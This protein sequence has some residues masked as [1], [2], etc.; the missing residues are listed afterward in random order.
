MGRACAVNKTRLFV[1]V[2]LALCGVALVYALSGHNYLGYALWLIAALNLLFCFL[3]KRAKIA[4]GALIALGIV[5]FVIIEIPIVE[6]AAPDD[7]VS[8]D[9]IIVLGAA[10]HGDTPSLSMVERVS[11]AYDYMTAHPG[12]TAVLSGGQ[13]GNENMSEAEAMYRWLLDKGISPDRLITED[14]STSTL[15]NLRFSLDIIRQ[16]GGDTGSVAVVSSEYHI[17]R[18]KL[19]G[20]TLGVSLAGIPAH[21]SYPSVRLN[22]FIREAFG[23]VYQKT[24]G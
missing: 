15:E 6:N 1:S 11:A 18:A 8:A 12:C 4:L 14:R 3:S 5:F 19:I 22:Y 17:Y 16:S 13:G 23:V 7:D 10:V 21:T 9:W 20:E 2:A 24:F